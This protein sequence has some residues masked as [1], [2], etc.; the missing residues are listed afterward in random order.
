M[1]AIAMW[2]TIGL[3][4]AAIWFFIQGEWKI[5]LFTLAVDFVF[6]WICGYMMMQNDKRR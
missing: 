1:K 4:G 6:S 5:G 2:I 3:M